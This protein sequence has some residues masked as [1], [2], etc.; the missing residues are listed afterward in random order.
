[1]TH[2]VELRN[3]TK[4]FRKNTALDRVSFTVA[5]GSVC[6][7]LGRNGA[8]K[9]TLMS[10]LSGQDRPTSGTV[11]ING[12]TPYENAD[13]LAQISYIR[14]N[15]RYPD[16]YYLRH[17]LR[18]APAFAQR[19]DADL[20]A[21]LA[22]GFQIPGKTKIKKLSR[23]Q[24]SAIAIILGLASRA[25]LTLFDEPYLGLDVGARHFFYDI[26]LREITT[27]PRTVLF[28]TH[29]VEEAEPLFDHVLL[30]NEGRIVMDGAPDEIRKT[31]YIASGAGERI[32]SFLSNKRVLNQQNT[33]SL[34]SAVVDGELTDAVASEA[35]ASG[36]QV[37]TATL[38]DLML[39]QGNPAQPISPDHLSPAS[40]S[41]VA[42][43]MPPP[44]KDFS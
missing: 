33:G 38:Q 24:L 15:Q 36:V 31:A 6:G 23:G 26:L 41:P 13:T 14:D 12:Q 1:M 27:T 20:A 22:D 2:T 35:L 10:L 18:I 37:T 30:L 32:T 29:L 11:T 40:A 44:P 4:S 9:T 5:A 8:G 16:D 3:V 19:W 17:V 34:R 25:P 28:S 42:S 7:L 21:E 43:S 39:A